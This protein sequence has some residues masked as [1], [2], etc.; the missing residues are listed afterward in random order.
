MIDKN[1]S[2]M[3]EVPDK[4]LEKDTLIEDQKKRIIFLEEELQQRHEELEAHVEELEAH[5]EELNNV[6]IERKQI[7]ERN[8]FLAAIVESSEDAIISKTLDGIITSWNDSAE[9]MFGYTTDEI[10]GKSKS[11][12]I[13]SDH[14]G[15]L[16][17]IL[18]KIKNGERIEHY[19][20]V[21]LRKDGERIDVSISVSPIK[22]VSG[23]IIGAANIIRNITERTRAVQKIAY[24]ASFPEKNPNPIIEIDDTGAIKYTNPSS[25][26]LFPDLRS[27]GAS[28]RTLDGIGPEMIKQD[29]K[30]PIVR[31]VLVNDAFYQQTILYMPESKTFRIYFI[32]ITKRKR[33]EDALRKNEAELANA[34]RIT[35]LGNW[36]WDT[37]RDEIHCSK[38]F[39][40]IFGMDVREFITYEQFINTLNPLDREPV[41]KAVNE[42]FYSEVP[43][44]IDYRVIWPDDSEH[45]I[46]A[47]G[48]VNLDRAGKPILMFGTVQDITERKR[49]EIE[50]QNT[51]AQLEMYNDLLGHDINNLNQIGIGYLELAIE[52]LRLSEEDKE[53]LSKPLEALINSSKLIENVKKLQQIRIGEGRHEEMDVN[54][55]L[56]DVKKAY[57]N[58]RERAVV[59]NYSPLPCCMVMTNELLREVFS[60]LVGNAIKHST[61]T[62]EINIGVSRV[63]ENGREYCRAFVE[64]NGPGIPDTLKNKLFNRFQSGDT[65]VSG[66]GLG[67]YLV[68]MLVDD[69]GGRLWVEDRVPGDYSKG[70]R[71]VVLLPAVEE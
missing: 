50:L 19:E 44:K 42:A 64:D 35:H 2:V 21:R 45:I 70:S 40:R 16:A 57:S 30:N 24:I 46:H 48:E 37:K 9:K 71:F 63:S 20:T 3:D 14:A 31:D 51:K 69:Y 65:K 62:L 60:N 7:E 61:G 33:A 13:P 49:A 67:L 34:Q 29:R 22:D 28:H 43:Y 36:I 18:N 8:S 6:I 17:Y 66:K 56:Q 27:S 59:I 26:R 25:D 4:M 15:E 23:K 1:M 53:M 5:V 10:I 54:L 39:Y 58:I 52:T 12:I 41:N 38:E 11:I 32:D 55:V 47:E 68:K